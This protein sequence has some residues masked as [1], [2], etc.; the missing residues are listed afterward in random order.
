M[1]EK[2]TEDQSG[3][4]KATSD[5]DNDALSAL[6]P[7]GVLITIVHGTEE[8][9]KHDDSPQDTADSIQAKTDSEGNTSLRFWSLNT[10]REFRVPVEEIQE[11]PYGLFVIPA[12]AR[13]KPL[14]LSHQM[15]ENQRQFIQHSRESEF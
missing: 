5:W 8:S 12:E 14:M 10:G 11:R 3:E 9:S 1:T 13:M 15:S 2:M 6:F 7:D 4:T